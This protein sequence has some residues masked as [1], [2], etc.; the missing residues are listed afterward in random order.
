MR[1]RD[2]RRS[3][4]FRLVLGCFAFFIVSALV[5]GVLLFFGFQHFVER[6]SR[7]Q[8]TE[9]L[10][11]SVDG[12]ADIDAW[13]GEM[14]RHVRRAR[15]APLNEFVYA[16]FDAQ[17]G[18]PTVGDARHD[19]TDCPTST[20][21]S[22][23]PGV[24]VKTGW[25]RFALSLGT[26]PPIRMFAWVEM[27]PSGHRLLVG[28]PVEVEGIFF[29]RLTGLAALA[30]AI[31][32]VCGLVGSWV[33]CRRLLSRIDRINATCRE[34]GV[35]SLEQRVAIGDQPDELAELADNINAMLDRISDLV[36]TLSGFTDQV[37]HDLRTP[38][39]RLRAKLEGLT[40]R[41]GSTNA[42][43]RGRGAIEDVDAILETFNAL[44]SVARAESNM[45][46]APMS[47]AAIVENVV[48]L[49]RPLAEDKPLKLRV[50]T[51][52]AVILGQKALLT[53]MIANLLDNAI[54]FTPVHGTITVSIESSAD[55]IRLI[56][57]DTGPGI[58]ADE[59]SR[60]FER[61]HRG[62]GVGATAG[63]GLGL[64]LVRIIAK[65]HR[66]TIAI[67]DNA[68]GLRIV[69]E[70]HPW[71][72]PVTA[73]EGERRARHRPAPGWSSAQPAS[74]SARNRRWWR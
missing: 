46:F 15:Q 73:A 61:F 41:A 63:H 18:C 10:I 65:R 39:T 36:Q 2:A 54:K 28:R 13:I 14:T 48:E 68:P 52:P 55:S 4:L 42:V 40:A 8:I 17:G 20:I 26:G 30:I 69:I 12:P 67:E 33:V 21:G 53:Q 11:R 60:L 44:L 45:A 50:R 56:I 22:W 58:A 31:V 1:R 32:I 9:Q 72:P 16:L 59:R 57:A 25:V 7:A 19:L 3:A 71:S 35:A 6:N 24:P 47:L 70:G 38:L 64:H 74:E 34:I 43:E 23:P 62:G 29:D 27:L 66:M 37:A 5:I 49:Y 51:A